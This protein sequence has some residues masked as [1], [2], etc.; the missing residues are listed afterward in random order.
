MLVPGAPAA[1]VPEAGA[2][3][4]AL[5][6]RPTA[7]PFRPGAALQLAIPAP[8][9]QPDVRILDASG[10]IVRSLDTGV[11][12]PGIHGVH[13]DGLDRAG[14]PVP[15]GVYFIRALLGQSETSNR[16]VLVR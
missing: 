15:A 14:R 5:S 9:G 11:L 10:R 16:V 2:A 4:L 1:D 7:N 13:W 12:S 8:G 3:P 6:L